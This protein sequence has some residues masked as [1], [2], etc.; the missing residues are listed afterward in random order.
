MRR[1]A[2]DGGLR[3]VYAA[4]KGMM[5]NPVV[6]KALAHGKPMRRCT[7]ARV[8]QRLPDGE[9]DA[10]SRSGDPVY[11]DHAGWRDMHTNIY[12]VSTLTRNADNG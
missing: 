10:G 9:A 2:S 4:A 3:R 12:A 7:A 6:T 5:Y 11:R 1:M 8:R